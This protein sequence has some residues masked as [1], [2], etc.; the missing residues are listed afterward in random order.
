MT[1]DQ[2]HRSL[3]I[4]GPAGQLEALLW[5]PASSG[6]YTTPAFAAVVCHPH[7]LFGGTMHNKVVY[8][9]AKLLDSFGVP[10]LRFNFRGVGLSAGRHDDGRGELED[11]N[12]ALN[13]MTG[14]YPGAPLMVAG[15]SFGAWVG[16]RAGCADARV[17][18]LVGLGLPVNA[19]D[20]DFG[21]LS[22]CA[23][24]KLFLQG[25]QDEHGSKEK[26][27]LLVA[28]FPPEIAST[29]RVMFIPEADHFFRDRLD[30]MTDALTQ[31]FAER[32]PDFRTA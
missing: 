2:Q 3:M 31:W 30:Q 21:F 1:P 6:Q 16:L 10:V 24:P 17:S 28:K 9:T 27:E 14:E 20:R 26:L 25:A 5:S 23:K 18:E 8:Q 12:A 4:A 11:V 22:R 13:F 32:H 15:F 19:D 29:T 7:P